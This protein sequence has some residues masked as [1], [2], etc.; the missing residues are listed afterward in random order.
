MGSPPHKVTLKLGS[1][2]AGTESHW[3]S[4]GRREGAGAWRRAREWNVCLEGPAG[5][6]AGTARGA[7]AGARAPGLGPGCAGRR[8]GGGTGHAAGGSRARSGRAGP[9]GARR[10][11]RGEEGVCGRGPGGRRDFPRPA[12]QRGSRSHRRLTELGHG[13]PVVQLKFGSLRRTEFPGRKSV[14]ARSGIC[15]GWVA[16]LP[17]AGDPA[18][19]RLRLENFFW[20][21]AASQRS[22]GRGG[23]GGGR[24]A[25]GGVAVGTAASSRRRAVCGGEGAVVRMGS[26]G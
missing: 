6:G 17:L 14:L 1:G 12:E 25:R 20:R 8:Q 21:L 9:R 24:R 16:F 19:R 13:A 5:V 15:W 3:G 7:A 2:A 22:G 10:R 26:R 18:P 4:R 23:P 11:A